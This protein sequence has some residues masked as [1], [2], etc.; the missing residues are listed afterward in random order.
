MEELTFIYTP[1]W[2]KEKQMNN[3]TNNTILDSTYYMSNDREMS[4]MDTMWNADLMQVRAY[5]G[6]TCHTLHSEGTCSCDVPCENTITCPTITHECEC[7]QKCDDPSDYY[8]IHGQEYE[9]MLHD[10]A[11]KAFWK[12][13][14]T[15]SPR[16]QEVF[17]LGV[18]YLDRVEQAYTPGK[19]RPLPYK[20]Y[21][22][23][24]AFRA[25]INLFRYELYV[26]TYEQWAY[27]TNYLNVLTS[28][29]N[30]E[31]EIKQYDCEIQGVVGNVDKKQDK[32]PN[33]CDVAYEIISCW[34]S[35][36]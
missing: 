35:I 22:A 5:E 26:L 28:W 25:R 31:G 2:G 7:E 32:E 11:I 6:C 1:I 16:G 12:S 13:T 36:D 14:T 21:Q 29:T 15:I 18:K 4:L 30:K 20:V 23:T 10:I 27:L 9:G 33:P 24:K 17:D 34:Y 8:P 3:T 19:A